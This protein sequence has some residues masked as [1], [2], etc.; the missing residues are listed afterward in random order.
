[1]KC[2]NYYKFVEP[3]L[4]YR[5]Y[6]RS[7]VDMKNLGDQAPIIIDLGCCTGTDLRKLMLDGYPG[8]K[9]YGI[10]INQH[11]IDTGYD[12]FLDQDHC[13]ITFLVGDIFTTPIPSYLHQRVGVIYTGSV[14]HLFSLTQFH[15]LMALITT[16]FLLP[17]GLFMGTQVVADA[18]TSMTRRGNTKHFIGMQDFKE[19]LERHHFV[20]IELCKEPEPRQKD[21]DEDVDLNT[22]WLSFRCRLGTSTN[23][24]TSIVDV[25]D[26]DNKV[27]E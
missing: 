25:H 18:T 21:P 20:D 3:R 12:L 23:T 5:F 22:Y 9:L 17:N 24:S 10:D 6:Y 14:I 26:D 1:Y 4:S 11:Y 15:T 19:A 7:L 8:N 16:Q 2:I 13:P 27:D